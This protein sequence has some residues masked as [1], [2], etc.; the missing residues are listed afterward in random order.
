MNLL[1]GGNGRSPATR[2]LSLLVAAALVS[3]GCTADFATQ[4][5][6][7]VILTITHILGQ[8]G[9]EGVDDGDV[10]FSDVTPVFNDNAAIT[11]FLIP[12][13]PNELLIGNFNDVFL[14][15][16]EVRFIRSD[17]RNTE[18]VDVPFRFTGAMA[19]MVPVNT[20]TTAV[21]VVVR[22]SAKEEPPLR[23]LAFFPQVDVNNGVGGGEGIIHAIAEI[24][25]HGRTVSGRAVTAFGRLTVTFADFGGSGLQQP[26]PV[27]SA[28]PTP[29]PAS[30]SPLPS[31]SASP[32]PT[33]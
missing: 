31:P 19:T 28:Q 18:G 13:N 6:A 2:L 29:V 27:P 23:N 33:K 12:K 15:R 5:E 20:I 32:S 9:N 21:I 8:P 11:F 26:S 3:F 30:P 17:G 14:E 24:T 10:L 22:H 4:S 16:Y 25:V 1:R 7:D